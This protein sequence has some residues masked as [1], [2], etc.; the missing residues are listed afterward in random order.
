MRADSSVTMCRPCQV[1]LVLANA[2]LLQVLV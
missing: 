1:M 2:V